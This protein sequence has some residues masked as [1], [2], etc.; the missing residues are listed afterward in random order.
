M[1][2][3]KILNFIELVLEQMPADWLNLTTH[4]LDIY[5]EKLAKTQFLTAFESLFNQYQTAPENLGA[6]LVA[7]P[8]SYDY[9]R[10]GHPLSCVLE[11]TLAKLNQLKPEN[12]ISFSSRTAPIL[13][14]LRKN[15]LANKKTKIFYKG[16][17][18]D[19][20]DAELVR[21]VYGYHFELKQVENAKQVSKEANESTVFISSTDTRFEF[22]LL[23]NIDFFIQI[24]SQL[25]SLILVN[26]A[27]NDG[28][29]SEIQ[30]VRRR[31]TIAMTPANTLIALYQLLGKA[32]Q[33][34]AETDHDA[35]AAKASVLAS[36]QEIT[37]SD[38]RA[39]VASSGLSMQYAIVM[40]LVHEALDQ[41]PGKAIK[42]V[43]P[44]NCY[45]G[46]NDQAR[47]VAACIDQVEVVDLPVDGGNDMV[48]SIDIVLD[49]IAKED[50]IPYII[51]E[52]PT[53]PRVEVP[54]LQKL[55]EVLSK[56]RTTS[57]GNQALDPVFILDQTFC[58]NFHFL[59]ESEILSSIRTIAYVSGSKFPSGGKC[60]A[61]FCVSNKKAKALM[62]KIDLHLQLCDNEATPIQLEILAKQLP[63]MNQRI[64]DAYRNTREFVN[65]IS[66]NLRGAKIN[67]VS[68]ELAAQG[69]TPSVFSLDLPTKGTTAEEREAYKRALNLQ[70]IELMIQKIPSE[71]KYCVSYGQ[72]KGCYWTI[73]AT[74]TQGTTKEVDK[75]YILRVA[76]SPDMNLELHKEVFLEFVRGL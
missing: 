68:E 6:A 29:I 64:Q 44:P 63:S 69:F 25:G 30:H 55:K 38:I 20:F 47:R 22:K 48:R 49:Q 67:F 23:P 14:I 11:W 9:I 65:F 34:S 1:K 24:Q 13:A 51:V 71:S 58:P 8:T 39:V 72:L 76:L 12:V 40:G 50:A 21:R 61:G 46:T 54:D 45:G 4:R 57:A 60:T 17:L 5:D 31:E 73:P 28:Y 66:A 15:L 75:D 2:D 42:L 19:F 62:P 74:S 43:I 32:S 16:E 26:G 37:G 33:K 18:P 56:S 36:I 10:L 7:L 41:H 53:N 27:Q 70:L 59:G 35:A 3:E 52:I